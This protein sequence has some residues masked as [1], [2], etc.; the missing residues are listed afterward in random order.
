MH[1]ATRLEGMMSEQVS[2]IDGV[3]RVTVVNGIAHM[4]L[5]AV[6]PPVQEG[7]QAQVVVTHRLALGLP[8]FV[9]MC[10]EMAGHLQRMEAKGLITRT[11]TQA[12]PG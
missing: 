4:D 6:L 8:Q 12:A 10:A 3:G 2:Y 7:A 11:P 5:V 1:A 9:R